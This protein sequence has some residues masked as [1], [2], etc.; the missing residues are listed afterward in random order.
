VCVC[1]CVCV[2][3]TI[4]DV[5]KLTVVKKRRQQMIKTKMKQLRLLMGLIIFDV[6]DVF[7]SA[8]GPLW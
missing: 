4:M 7:G 1:E 3:L 6:L 5:K 2:N 8:E